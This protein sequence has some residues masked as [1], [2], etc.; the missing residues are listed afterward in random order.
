[1]RSSQAAIDLIVAEEVSSREVYEERYQHP[2][3]PGG[4]SG[5]TVGIGYDCGY[6]TASE[7]ERDWGG[8]LSVPMIT[9]LGRV[10]GL[11]AGQAHG[12]LSQVKSTVVVPWDA[13]MAVFENRDVPKYEKLLDRAVPHAVELPP[14][15]YGVLLSV[16][17][18]RGA[19]GWTSTGERY[20]EMRAI[21]D[22]I[23]NAQWQLI[24][25]EI[26][27]MK[28]LWDPQKQAGLI[29]R[30]EHEAVLFE[31]GLAEGGSSPVT[32]QGSSEE[33][34]PER[35]INVQPEKAKY[36]LA[37]EVLQRKLIFMNF[38]EVGD[39]DG[40]F[41]GKTR[42]AVTAFMNDRGKPTD[43]MITADVVNEVNKALS[44]GWSRPI[45]PERTNA[46]AKDIA[47]K[48]PIVNQTFWQKVWAYVLGTPAA[49]L[50]VFKAVFGDKGDTVSSYV[51][52]VRDFFAAIPAELYIFAVLGIAVAIFVQAKRV[53]DQTV[54]S[55]R[56]GEIN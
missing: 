29:H 45:A 54:I 10:A 17:Y 25:D 18:N 49:G 32:P 21:K 15:C 4:M 39:A 51:Q 19:G 37:V 41:G 33:D 48:V 35:P 56:K 36:D 53:Q 44:E 42:G 24:P 34:Q 13:A 31:K 26:R 28:R 7:I 16:T 11:K 3:F 8:Y 20:R 55:Y 5:I 12:A 14:T 52:P 46:T 43:G 6:V 22:H 27:S 30:R 40:K 47:N 23:D 2:E 9:A 38:H 50:G 1:M